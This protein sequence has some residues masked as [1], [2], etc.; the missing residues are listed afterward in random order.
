VRADGEWHVIEDYVG[1]GIGSRMHMEPPVPNYGAP[2]KGPQL[3]V[4]MA[5]AIE[6][7]ITVGTIDTRVLEDDW[8]VVTIDDSKAAHWEHTVCITEQGPWV[9]TALDGGAARLRALGLDVPERP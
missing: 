1:H 6:P 2:G 4:G 8:T 5:L 3:R 7:M 9:T